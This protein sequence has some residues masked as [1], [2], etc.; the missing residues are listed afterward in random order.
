MQS[1]KQRSVDASRY[2]MVPRAEVPRS[3]FDI[4]HAYKTTFDAGLLIPVLVQEILPGDSMRVQMT[5]FAR[6]STA[7]VPIMDNLHLES[8]FFFVPNRLTWTNWERF[9]GEQLT[10][11]DSTDFLV[12]Q[13]SIAGTDLTIGSIFDYMGL[14]LNGQAGP[15]LVNAL[16]FRAYNLIWNDW[17][18]DQDLQDPIV[19]PLTEGPDAASSYALLRR[20]KRHDYFTTCRPWPEKPSAV[21][22][23]GGFNPLVPGGRFTLPPGAVG[24]PVTGIGSTAGTAG[25]VAVRETGGRQRTYD[26]RFTS[27]NT[28]VLATGL[29]GFPNV[30][31]LIND[32]RTANQ[33]QRLME[34]NARSGT[35][36]AEIIRDLWGVTSPD[37]RLQRPEYLGGGR[38]QVTVNPV[39]QTSATGQTGSTTVLGELAGVGTAVMSGH[40][41]SSSFTEHGFVIGMV[42]VRADLTYQQGIER[43]WNRRTR[44][45]HYVPQLAHLGEQAVL[46]REIFS[47]GSAADLTVFGYQGRWDEY[48]NKPNR[49]TGHFSSLSPD[50][51]DVW[52]L[53]QQFE[54][55]PLLNAAFVEDRPPV[56]RVLALDSA[57]F[58]NQQFLLDAIFDMRMVRCMPMFSIPG[59]GERL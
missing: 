24:A 36:Y 51:L 35:R 19:T 9:M 55:A 6:L 16:P 37:A 34:R 38:T 1:R 46:R 25:S 47:V 28:T 23:S 50:T 21:T 10:I 48:R 15:L 31:V 13:V 32:I 41:F 20:G 56:D 26:H 3:A 54:S 11:T 59:L 43:M 27:S 49:V 44:Y 39:A 22:D 45:D 8:F 53:A 52:H 57:E 40:S 42:Q 14:T 30:R 58:P 7:I 5:A 2:A 29:D 4:S 12:P 17:F 18:R 33:I